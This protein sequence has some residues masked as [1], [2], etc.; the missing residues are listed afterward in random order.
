[1]LLIRGANVFDGR[2]FSEEE[3]VVVDSGRALAVGPES[4]VEFPPVTRALDGRNL[5]LLPGFID[6]HVHIGFYDPRVVLAGGIT[7]ARDLGWPAKRIFP[8][9]EKLRRSSQDGP[10]L[11]AAG[12][13]LTAPGGYPSR[14][15]WAPRATAL[16]IRDEEQAREAVRTLKSSGAA[17]IKVAQDPR[18]GPVLTPS[19]LRTIVD[20]AH[21][22]DL[23]VTSHLGSLDQLEVA[24][25]AGVDELA[26][27]LWSD[28]EIPAAIIDRMVS[29]GMTVI[30]TLHIDPSPVRIENLRKFHEA[31][32]RVIYGTDMG[33]TGPPPGIDPTELSLMRK[34]GMSV[35]DV[36]ASATSAAARHLGLGGRGVIEAEAPADLVLID[37]DPRDDFRVL[38]NVVRVFRSG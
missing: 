18:A 29:Q 2:Q 26:H 16:E 30:P 12:P 33:N 37:G 22:A 10:I 23:K 20:E 5:T 9:V 6:A 14:A 11:V 4:E 19:V 7:A 27:G 31:G 34:A 3:S 21:S 8:L 13:I 38:S 25:D 32:G 17:I 35:E 15:G 28:E 24:L 36:L 1:M